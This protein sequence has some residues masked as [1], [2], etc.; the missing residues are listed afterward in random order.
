M[1]D[2]ICI[3]ETPGYTGY[4]ATCFTVGKISVM[5]GEKEKDG[6]F[7]ARPSWNKI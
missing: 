7:G 2:W 1:G 4:T 5:S 6:K 3:R